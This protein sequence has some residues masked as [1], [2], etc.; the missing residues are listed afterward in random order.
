ML[1]LGR[2]RDCGRDDRRSESTDAWEACEDVK[3]TAAAVVDSGDAADMLAL[4]VDEERGKCRRTLLDCRLPLRLTPG[5]MA[6]RNPRRRVPPGSENALR[7]RRSLISASESEDSSQ[8]MGGKCSDDCIRAA[9]HKSRCDGVC[10][11][12]TG[13]GGCE[14]PTGRRGS[15]PF[16]VR[17]NKSSSPRL[18][19]DICEEDDS[20][21]VRVLAVAL[22]LTNRR[23]FPNPVVSRELLLDGAEETE[24]GPETKGGLCNMEFGKNPSTS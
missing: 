9:S 1:P 10:G 19:V 20:A 2:C 12:T 14:L 22:D 16:N 15:S 6:S 5:E 18:C 23:R 11:G 13:A 3:R 17:A 24:I 8:T 4:E 7:L 21:V